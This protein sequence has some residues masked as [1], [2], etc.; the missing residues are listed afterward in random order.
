MSA[1]LDRILVLGGTGMLGHEVVRGLAE[2]HEVHA[3]VRDEEAARR[4]GVG[5]E[6]HTF[7]AGRPEGLGDL[8][9]AVRP[10]AVVNCIGLVKQL[11]EA[12]RPASAVALNA[13]FPHQAAEA[14]AQHGARFV[15]VSTDCV[16]AGDLAPPGRYTEDDAP[17][18]RDLY[19]LSKLLGEVRAPGALTIR[20]SIIGW[21]LER[22]S[23]LLEWLASQT[24][25]PVRG[26]ANAWFSGLTTRALTGV[27]EALL[28]DHPSLEGLFHVASE[29]INKYDLV[30]ALNEALGLGCTV[31]RS[32]EPRINRSL[33][34]ARFRAAT[35][36]EPPSW[37]DMIDSYRTERV[38]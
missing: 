1:A 26:F 34:P 4:H 14:A 37:A 5:G 35:D 24:G 38:A 7:D 2:R 25:K 16:F 36:I 10:A 32:E 20:T 12:A 13:L 22:A 31:E 9:G 8:L 19:G 15:H 28:R 17:D 29:P 3:T 27:I 21:E 18:A 33:D 30:V 11:E 6:L 23:G